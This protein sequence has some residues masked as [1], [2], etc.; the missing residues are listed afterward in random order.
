MKARPLLRT[1]GLWAA[2]L[3]IALR[4]TASSP[5]KEKTVTLEIQGM[6]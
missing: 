2:F 1:R 3:L 4:L 6:V 5:P